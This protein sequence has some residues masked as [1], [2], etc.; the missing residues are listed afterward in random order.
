MDFH[1]FAKEYGIRFE[2]EAEAEA[3]TKAEAEAE[4]EAGD[5]PAVPRTRADIPRR[6]RRSSVGRGL[7]HEPA[8]GW[9]LDRVLVGVA[10]LRTLRQVVRPHRLREANVDWVRAFDISLWSGVTPQGSRHAMERLRSAGILKTASRAHFGRAER[11]MIDAY[12]PLTRAFE[13]LF[14]AEQRALAA[15]RARRGF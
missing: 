2:A 4:A 3:E 6:R 13:T 1:T 11:F 10:T 5:L 8:E 9:P 12:H 7:A 15:R 14:E